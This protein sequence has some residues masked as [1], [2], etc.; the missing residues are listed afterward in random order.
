MTSSSLRSRPITPSI[1]TQL[2][3][4]YNIG[5]IDVTSSAH[6]GSTRVHVAINKTSV[7]SNFKNGF[8][9]SDKTISIEAEQTSRR[10]QSA[11]V[12]YKVIPRLGRTLSGITLY[13]RLAPTQFPTK[14]SCPRVMT[15]IL[16]LNQLMG[17]ISPCI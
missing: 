11:D 7:P 14:L 9:K 6:Y 5:F 8:V 15:F 1:E 10:T 17:P 16:L 13:P 4:G 2:G 3:E 12:H